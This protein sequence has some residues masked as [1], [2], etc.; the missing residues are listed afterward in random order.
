MKKAFIIFAI[1]FALT[2]AVPAIAVLVKDTGTAG[3]AVTGCISL[4]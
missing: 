3:A 1:L 4:F 2:L